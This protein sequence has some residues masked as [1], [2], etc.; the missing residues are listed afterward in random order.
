MDMRK[1]TFLARLIRNERG[2]SAVEMGLICAMIVLAMFAALQG[3]A[4]ESN[5]TWELIASK[6]A[7]ASQKANAA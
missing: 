3:M 6:S 5:A 7:E 4:E 1:T 2:T